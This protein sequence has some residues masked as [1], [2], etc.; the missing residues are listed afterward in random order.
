RGSLRKS[1]NLSVLVIVY[2]NVDIF[3]T[4]A[5]LRAATF[6]LKPFCERVG[7]YMALTARDRAAELN[8]SL[9]QSAAGRRL[10][11]RPSLPLAFDEIK[12]SKNKCFMVGIVA[13]LPCAH[14]NNM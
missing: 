4:P 7:H 14:A 6:R 11:G 10:G 13:P 9:R 2:A 8:V 3:L 12:S 5:A 1:F